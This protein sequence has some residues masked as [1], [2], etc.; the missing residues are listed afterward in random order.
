MLRE[1]RERRRLVESDGAGE[2]EGIQE[3]RKGRTHDRR[4]IMIGKEA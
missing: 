1:I 4:G 2:Q 3:H